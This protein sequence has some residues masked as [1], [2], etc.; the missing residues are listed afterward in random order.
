MPFTNEL[1]RYCGVHGGS[2]CDTTI[3]GVSAAAGPILWVIAAIRP[4]VDN[5]RNWLV[6]LGAGC[7]A[8]GVLLAVAASI[9]KRRS[10]KATLRTGAHRLASEWRRG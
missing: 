9:A 1:T 4:Y 6:L 5:Q 3:G 8:T 7:M 10:V 2:R